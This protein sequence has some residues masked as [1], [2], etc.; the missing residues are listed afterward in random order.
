[1]SKFTT[2][3]ENQK[4]C[5]EFMKDPN[6]KDSYGNVTL[7]IDTKE[8][9]MLRLSL[10]PEESKN[11]IDAKWGLDGSKYCSNF[12]ALDTKFKV[13]DSR[14]MYIEALSRLERTKALVANQDGDFA[15]TFEDYTSDDFNEACLYADI[16][17]AIFGTYDLSPYG[18]TLEDFKQAFEEASHSLPEKETNVLK[19]HFGI[20]EYEKQMTLEETGNE[21]MITKELV[22]KMENT[23]F[24]KLR[25]PILSS[26][27]L[28]ADPDLAY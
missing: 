1:M 13:E 18:G 17:V 6:P 22:K 4:R 11:I 24:R 2:V 7:G 23:I 9:L 28:F 10:L 5:M 15:C 12:K 26:K 3:Q 8:E 16:R 14:S 21:F 20:N 19:F 25:N 27:L